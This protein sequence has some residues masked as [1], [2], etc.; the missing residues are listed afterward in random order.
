M[1]PSARLLSGVASVFLVA[2]M[3]SAAPVAARLSPEAMRLL[4]PS[5]TF[6][7]ACGQGAKRSLLPARLQL[8][9]ATDTAAALDKTPPLYEGLG[10]ISFDISTG[11]ERA[12]AYFNQGLTFLYGFNHEE[13]IRAFREAQ[14]LDPK[15][16]MCFW[17]EAFAHGPNINAPM[18][19]ATIA[20]TIAALEKARA[21]KDTARP[22][23][24]ALIDALARRYT[25]DAKADRAA[26]DAAYAD[27][28]L[29]VAAAYP[30]D[31]DVAALAAE[32]QMDTQPWD[33]WEPGGVTPKGRIPA[34]ID[35]VEGIL[36]RDPNHAQ[37]D[38]L[39]IHLME[40][41]ANPGQAEAA[42]DRL[43]G[44]LVPASGHLVHMPGHLYYRIGRF[45]DSIRVNV[46]AAKVDEAYLAQSPLK[47][48][49]RFG[50]YPHNVHF[51]VTSAQMAGDMTTALQQADKL[52]Q[53]LNTDVTAQFPW[54]QPV[55]AAPYLAY[56]QFAAPA[57]IMALKAPDKR[58][59]YVTAMWH[60]ARAAAFAQNRDKRGFEGELAAMKRLADTTDWQPMI[61]GRVPVPTLLKLA[62]TVAR[63]KYAMAEGRHDDAIKLYEAAAA[64]EA[65]V[66]YMEPPYWYY[67]VRQSLGAARFAAGDYEG[68]KADFMA[69]IAQSP[70]NAWAL[71]GLQQA[72]LKLGDSAGAEATAAAFDKAWLGKD[73]WLTMARL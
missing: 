23:E 9:M 68:A 60:Y 39:Y 36:A 48:L 25:T 44:P 31:N 61:D 18:D 1:Q 32:A 8:A 42:A 14:R 49:Y 73:E 65:Q 57:Q 22:K 43:A 66:S 7:Q 53:V 69:T 20:P 46:D 55:D 72:Q 40:A 58:L 26:Y 6:L 28:M 64:L 41:S 3:P 70:N 71:W 38:H 21:L 15:C 52:R 2:L 67:P 13:A 24:A 47:G 17:G 51:I 63:G 27:E 59:P 45:A 10:K 56:A 33:Y 19:P 5:L 30:L 11:N 12:Q 50:Y 4:N 37:A 35:L 16:A 34:A 54:T 62:E 29:K